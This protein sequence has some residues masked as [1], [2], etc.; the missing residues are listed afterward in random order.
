M[1]GFYLFYA[2]QR[3]HHQV[4]YAMMEDVDAKI[5]IAIETLEAQFGRQTRF[6]ER[7]PMDQLIATILSQRTNYANE[8]KAFDRMW[9]R[10]GSWENIM[11]ASLPALTEAI[12]S[13]NYP[14]VKAPRIQQVL[15][16]IKEE[17]GDFDLNFLATMPVED[18]LVWLMK[19]PGV[20][21]KTATFLLLFTFRKPVLPVDTHVHRVSQRLGIITKKIN[22]AKAHTVLLSMLPREAEVLLNFHKL[23]FKHGQNICTWSQPHC[24]ACALTKICDYFYSQKQNIF[25]T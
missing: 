25:L 21:H 20:G 19:M 6:S 12:A 11:E 7:P 13:S 8:R 4:T 24:S 18:A 3:S 2:K 15:R 16:L 10:F 22:Q 1:A 9:E 23:F 14:E 5:R 17:R